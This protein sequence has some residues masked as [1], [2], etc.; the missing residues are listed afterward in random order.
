MEYRRTWVQNCKWL[1]A[2]L[3]FLS[4]ITLSG[5]AWV[6]AQEELQ[7]VEVTEEAPQEIEGIAVAEA[8]ETEQELIPLVNKSNGLDVVLVLDQSRSIWKKDEAIAARDTGARTAVSLCGGVDSTM[9]IVYFSGGF[10]SADS[11]AALPGVDDSSSEEE[12]AALERQRSILAEYADNADG[13]V[14]GEMAS[15]NKLRDRLMLIEDQIGVLSKNVTNES[16][17]IATGINR[18]LTMLQNGKNEEQVIILF[19]DGK[20]DTYD[21]N[22]DIEYVYDEQTRRAA[23]L[24]QER[25]VE[26]YVIYL[27]EFN[28]KQTDEEELR[29]LVNY[30]S[31]GQEYDSRF[32][33]V[34]DIEQLEEKFVTI[35]QEI[36]DVNY[37]RKNVNSD[38]TY[39]LSDLPSSDAQSVSMVFRGEDVQIESVSV[40]GKALDSET[41]L[42]NYGTG[43][44][45]ISAVYLD[46]VDS[47]SSYQ[48]RTN[49]KETQCYAVYN[50]TLQVKVEED[51]ARLRISLYNLDGEAICPDSGQ[52]VEIDYVDADGK[53]STAVQN[54]KSNGLEFVT[55]ELDF[56][57]ETEH[58]WQI[59]F[60]DSDG[61]VT[62]SCTYTG[63]RTGE[64]SQSEEEGVSFER[65]TPWVWMIPQWPERTA[66]KILTTEGSFSIANLYPSPEEGWDGVS[67]RAFSED[68]TEYLW[69]LNPISGK[70]AF[71]EE[72]ETVFA[73][74]FPWRKVSVLT[75]I[76][77]AD[78]TV[79]S[80]VVK[81]QLVNVTLILLI[82]AA[83]AAFAGGIAVKAV[84]KRVVK[85]VVKLI[86]WCGNK[87]KA[88]KTALHKEEAQKLREEFQ[89]LQKAAEKNQEKENEYAKQYRSLDMDLKYFGGDKT[90]TSLRNSVEAMKTAVKEY[91]DTYSP[92]MLTEKPYLG[93]TKTDEKSELE[94]QIERLEKG[95]NQAWKRR[96][97]SRLQQRMEEIRKQIQEAK[98]VQTNRAKVLDELPAKFK[99][100]GELLDSSEQEQQP[101]ACSL[102]LENDYF[103]AAVPWL[104]EYLT[105]RTAPVL[106]ENR[107]VLMKKPREHKENMI[108]QD[109]LRD[110][111]LNGKLYG[112]QVYG[113][114]YGVWLNSREVHTIW[115]DGQKLEWE[116]DPLRQGRSKILLEPGT[117]TMTLAGTLSD[118]KE[119]WILT[120]IDPMGSEV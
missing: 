59:V 4:G 15:L 7:V 17:N 23:A 41:I 25:G 77:W 49:S 9:G 79:D 50:S 102:V 101:F 113:D 3:L 30:Y 91:V 65:K 26:I 29:Q 40:D 110:Q 111:N 68:G 97:S 84:V 74:L 48:I 114:E 64:Q 108:L 69:E 61:Q 2:G 89:E 90:E 46:K 5:K 55:E 63:A 54:L 16:T 103:L 31:G 82:L 47:E 99:E 106:L 36:S 60:R 119:E 39:T 34:D 1:L 85:F 100:V 8:T 58:S 112:C 80:A 72:Y 109:Y 86:S 118:R 52:S 83:F 87:S 98:Q 33:Q 67:V 56:D 51:G 35:L 18:A 44:N 11:P 43:E 78:G 117:Y 28:E 105:R 94:Q 71:T 107:P 10:L 88:K 42:Y 76:T 45:S 13:S 12:Q 115:Q 14:C 38:G 24:A 92:D 116:N 66:E 96:D 62:G 73:F 32:Y 21:D 104:D 75:E 120:V 6:S 70:I 19:S 27:S 20:N 37:I 93:E 53:K 22:A 95:E 57:R 81:L